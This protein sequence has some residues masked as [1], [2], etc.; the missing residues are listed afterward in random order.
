M[1]TAP[2]IITRTVNGSRILAGLQQ[3]KP[4]THVPNTTLNEAYGIFAGQMPTDGDTPRTRYFGIGMN[5]HV[6]RTGSDGGH[7]TQARQHSPA[8]FGMYRPVPFLL[9]A[10][11]EDL[12]IAQR[13]AYGLRKIVQYGGENYI[14]Y[15]LKRIPIDNEPVKMLHNT[16]VDGVTTTVPFVPNTNNLN[17]TPVDPASVNVIGT[18]GTYLSTSAMMSLVFGPADVLELIEVAKIIYGSEERALISEIALVA[19][20]DRVQ[21]ITDPGQSAFNMNEVVMAQIT[22]HITGL[23]PVAYSSEGFTYDLDL[24]GVEPLVGITSGP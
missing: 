4:Y 19:G 9:R 12:N 16:V 13:A 17:P 18:N 24:G 5:G 11:N 3:G 6:N 15:F 22:T 1:A 20:C 21:S 23:W 8:D 7:Y 10:P 2:R 14:A